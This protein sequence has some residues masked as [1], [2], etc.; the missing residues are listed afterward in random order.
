MNYRRAISAVSYVS[1][2]MSSM[3]AAAFDSE[4]PQDT[5]EESAET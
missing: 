2:V 5:D 4:P 1:S 3:L